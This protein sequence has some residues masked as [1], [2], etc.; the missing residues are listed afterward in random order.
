[1]LRGGGIGSN[2]QHAHIGN[3]A[4]CGPDFLAVDDEFVALQFGTG[5][6]RG[7]VR[8][9]IWFRKPLAP[10]F[11]SG[12]HR[13]D[14]AAASFPRKRLVFAQSCGLTIRLREVLKTRTVVQPRL[15]RFDSGA[16]PLQVPRRWEGRA[17]N[18]LP[19]MAEPGSG[20]VSRDQGGLRPWAR[21]LTRCLRRV[22]RSRL[23]GATR[24]RSP[25]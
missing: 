17:P 24:P 12:K 9:G 6:Q 4:E 19:G 22:S 13:R 25:G 10:D 23:Q 11:L 2:K 3:M 5:L 21:R 7:E 15:G 18:R 20:E 8:P 1:M 14:E 16:A